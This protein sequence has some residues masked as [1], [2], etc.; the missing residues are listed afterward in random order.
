M[1][2]QKAKCFYGLFWLFWLDDV[3]I[4]SHGEL[5]GLHKRPWC[6]AENRDITVFLESRRLW[7][8]SWQEPMFSE[9]YF[10]ELPFSVGTLVKFVSFL[11][12]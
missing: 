5:G 4:P 12:S 10:G 6:Q 8:G 3:V 9:A 7:A 11:S 1:S 2:D